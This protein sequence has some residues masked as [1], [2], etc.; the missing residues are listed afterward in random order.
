MS[1]SSTIRS[2][3]PGR[4]SN[5]REPGRVRA[6]GRARR[7]VLIYS[8]HSSYSYPS[9]CNAASAAPWT[10]G[11]W[12]ARSLVTG[13]MARLSPICPSALAADPRT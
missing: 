2:P 13:L 6:I 1:S 8:P 3:R 5:S 7:A 4:T 10:V 12:S 9:F 11:Y